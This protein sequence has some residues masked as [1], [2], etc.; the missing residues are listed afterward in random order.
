LRFLLEYGCRE[1]TKLRQEEQERW[2]HFVV[3][4]RQTPQATF[5]EVEAVNS[6]VTATLHSPQQIVEF[7]RTNLKPA[8]EVPT[9]NRQAAKP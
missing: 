1:E 3:R 4:V 2:G 9:T 7:I 6:G 8:E 5:W